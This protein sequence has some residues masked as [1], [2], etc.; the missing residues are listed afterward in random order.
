MFQNMKIE[1]KFD[2]SNL[3][4]SRELEELQELI[5][6]ET[7]FTVEAETDFLEGMRGDIVTA[8]DLTLQVMPIVL[9]SI[10]VIVSIITLW[11]NQQ[12]DK[13]RTY[14]ATITL[15]GTNMPDATITETGISQ[16][17]AEA[18]LATYLKHPDSKIS[19]DIN[20]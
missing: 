6:N 13:G 17:S 20:S 8:L 10:T 4:T 15:K 7:D 3:A 5:E 19:V 1:I 16:E 9:S 12:K 2:E 11:K 14:Q 18:L